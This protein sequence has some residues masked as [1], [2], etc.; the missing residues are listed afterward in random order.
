MLQTRG[1]RRRREC[2]RCGHR[3]TTIEQL[4]IGSLSDEV[5]EAK[6]RVIRA[7]D[8]TAAKKKLIQV[9][10]AR[11]K[12]EERRWAK[13]SDWYSEDNNFLPEKW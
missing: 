11:D 3:F 12:I 13:E 4:L 1:V 7:P 5:K 8:V 2:L 9:K 10:K 6:P